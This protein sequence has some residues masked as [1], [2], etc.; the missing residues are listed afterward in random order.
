MKLVKQSESTT[1]EEFEDHP[2]TKRSLI[3]LHEENDT[4]LQTESDEK[5]IC[6]ELQMSVNCDYGLYTDHEIWL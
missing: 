6:K 3:E 2:P 4:K 5:Y 1:I